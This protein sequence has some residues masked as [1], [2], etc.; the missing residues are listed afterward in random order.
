MRNR[1]GARVSGTGADIVTAVM[2]SLQRRQKQVYHNHPTILTSP[3]TPQTPFPD[4]K[5]HISESPASTVPAADTPTAP[6]PSKYPPHNA[7][8]P[9]SGLVHTS[10]QPAS[11]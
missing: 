3:F 1:E 7:S 2:V 9:P 6:S 10:P 11:P 5:R 4:T 8:P